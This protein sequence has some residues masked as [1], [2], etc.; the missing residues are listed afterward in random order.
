MV[1]QEARFLGWMRVAQYLEPRLLQ[2]LAR[3]ERAVVEY[4]ASG[5]DLALLVLALGFLLGAVAWPFSTIWPALAA[6]DPAHAILTL[7]AALIS[8]PVFQRLRL[9]GAERGRRAL[10]ARGFGRSLGWFL[11]FGVAVIAVAKGLDTIG[12]AE[13]DRGTGR[14]LQAGAALALLAAA[15]GMYAYWLLR[16]RRRADLI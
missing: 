1:P 15:Q 4:V 10:G 13:P 11:I 9:G 7:A 14:L 6:P 3:R 12:G 8:A 16:F 2:L 5:L